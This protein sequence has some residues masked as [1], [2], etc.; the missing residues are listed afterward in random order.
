MKNVITVFILLLL[1]ISIISCHREDAFPANLTISGKI[2]DSCTGKGLKGTAA[3][4]KDNYHPSILNAR[5]KMGLTDDDGNYK[6]K[7]YAEKN[8]EYSLSVAA[9]YEGA[10]TP[11][12]LNK[13]PYDHIKRG[14][15]VNY[16][17]KLAEQS[18]LSIEYHDVNPY[19]APADSLYCV[20]TDNGQ[21]HS[22]K[23]F[24][25]HG[26]YNYGVDVHLCDCFPLK[27][28]LNWDATKNHITTHHIDSI[29]CSFTGQTVY[30][31]N[32]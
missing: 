22:N 32:Y 30:Y 15:N 23:Y 21:H 18:W 19:N 20:V 11:S 1:F 17:P 4:Y 7:F 29:N 16:S 6:I 8:K 14:A 25:A 28:Y 31:L 9:D 10:G 27:V 13:E 12:Y 3:L 24:T 5:L 26:D 2:T